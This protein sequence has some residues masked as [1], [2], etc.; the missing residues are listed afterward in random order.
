MF[1]KHITELGSG[2]SK[3]K[4]DCGKSEMEIKEQFKE[5]REGK[6]G[7]R[8]GKWDIENKQSNYGSDTCPACDDVN[9]AGLHDPLTPPSTDEK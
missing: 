1:R 4:S 6:M 9:I 3:M 7:S 8:A 2:K 5:S